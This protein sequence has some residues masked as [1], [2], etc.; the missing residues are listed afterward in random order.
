M[1]KDLKGSLVFDP[2]TPWR[3]SGVVLNIR[4]NKSWLG[5]NW[6]LVSCHGFVTNAEV[7]M[8][9]MMGWKVSFFLE[10]S[11]WI[12]GEMIQF[13]WYFSNGL[14]P[15][16]SLYVYIYIICVYIY[17]CYVCLWGE[18]DYGHAWTMKTLEDEWVWRTLSLKQWWH[19]LV[20]WNVLT[21]SSLFNFS[22]KVENN[23]VTSHEE[24]PNWLTYQC[25]SGFS[26]PT[27]YQYSNHP[28][29]FQSLSWEFKG[30][31]PM[32]P[33][34]RNKALLRDYEAHHHPLIRPY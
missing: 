11:N 1:A 33:P 22:R 14:K 12:F 17:I 25:S 32:P 16:T 3:C 15:P 28:P 26:E 21:R 2:L 19:E 8:T 31:L 34:P 18:R 27:K 23:M 5:Y 24:I 30:T 6:P 9:Y 20:Y 4:Y 13:D 7:R 10:V 29:C